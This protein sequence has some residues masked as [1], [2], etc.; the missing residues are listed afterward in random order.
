MSS[1][2]NSF[3]GEL[4]VQS[5]DIDGI[6]SEIKR[7]CFNLDMVF[8]FQVE[9]VNEQIH[10]ILNFTG[11]SENSPTFILRGE[12]AKR[13]LRT[14]RVEIPLEWLNVEVEA[15]SNH[16]QVPVVMTVGGS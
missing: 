6:K 11:M 4:L 14:T 13:F 1:T 10:L 15:T 9:L 7:I 3:C 12:D 5:W 2:W 8:G 16:F